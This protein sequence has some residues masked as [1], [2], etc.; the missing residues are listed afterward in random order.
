MSV[1]LTALKMLKKL[2]QD[3]LSSTAASNLMKFFGPT[4]QILIRCSGEKAGEHENLVIQLLSV[5]GL[6]MRLRLFWR[7]HTG[8][9]PSLNPSSTCPS[10]EI[11]TF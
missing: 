7:P 8:I 2:L 5:R 4:Y 6:S 3:S 11:S 10:P 9:T 1:S